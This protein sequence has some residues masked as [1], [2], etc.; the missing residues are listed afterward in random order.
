MAPNY[1][2]FI[3][4]GQ[5]EKF[6]KWKEAFNSKGLKV[7][8]RKTKVIVTGA[9]GEVFVSKVDPCGYLWEA[10]SSKFS[11]ECEMW[12]MDPWKMHKSKEGH[13]E[14]GRD[15]VYGRCKKQLDGLVEPVE[16]LCEEVETVRGFCYL[17]DRVNASVGF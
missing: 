9:E 10:S 15:F 4:E 11:V 14:V 2:K 3:I 16:E 12:E 17:G 6:W 13:P 8:L 5:R 7:N 1:F